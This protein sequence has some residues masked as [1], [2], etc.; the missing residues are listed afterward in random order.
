MVM[1]AIKI[2]HKMKNKS[3]LSIEKG[4]TK[5]EKI[6]ERSLDNVSVSS[7]KS[8]N[9]V[10]LVWSRLRLL[11]IKVVEIGAIL[12]QFKAFETKY[13]EFLY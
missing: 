8:E 1:K 13:I 9:G 2:S 7:Y 11:A 5:S 10:V 12:R 3:W 4:I 6:T